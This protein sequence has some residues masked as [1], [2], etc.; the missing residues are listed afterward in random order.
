MQYLTVHFTAGPESLE[1]YFKKGT[2]LG[3]KNIDSDIAGK[4]LNIHYWKETI[5]LCEYIYIYT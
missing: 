4:K 1:D 2:L 5:E 3:Q